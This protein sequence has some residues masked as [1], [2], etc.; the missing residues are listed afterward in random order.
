MELFVNAN[1]SV[2]ELIKRFNNIYP[3]LRL[4]IY[5]RGEEMGAISQSRLLKDIGNKKMIESFVITP[6]MKVVQI[7][8]LFWEN[9]GLQ[10]SIFRKSGR[11]WLESSFTNY[12]SLERQNGLGKEMNDFM[13]V[14]TKRMVI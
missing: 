11:T 14:E 13:N 5:Y 7:E 1:L 6:E 12:W 10:I 9:M 3:F 4:E 2:S 8:E